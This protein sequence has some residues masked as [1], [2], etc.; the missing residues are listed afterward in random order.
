MGPSL[1][2]K[3]PVLE[4]YTD[5]PVISEGSKS[6]VNCILLKL[7]PKDFA[8]ACTRVVFPTP[9]TSSISTW[10]LLSMATTI[11]SITLRFPTKARPTLST[12]F[13]AVLFISLNVFTP[14][15]CYT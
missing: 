12:I 10:P 7:H 4:L 9:G 2:S 6:G 8:M 13:K 14:I 11:F 1:N 15:I 3:L 5:I